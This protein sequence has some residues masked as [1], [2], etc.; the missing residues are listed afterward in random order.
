LPSFL[1]SRRAILIA[2]FAIVVVACLT[3]ADFW[4]AAPADVSIQFVG[5]Q[6]CIDCHQDQAASFL[7]SHHDLAMDV[8]TE[9]TVLG[10][11]SDVTFEHHGMVNRL[12][13]EG[14]KFMVHTEGETGKMEDFEVKYVFGVDPLQ[15]YMVEFDRDDFLKP[16]ELPR[17]QV[18]R[19]SWDVVKKQWFYLS[20]PDVQ[21]K[22]EPGDPL[23][24]TGI[25]QRWQTMCADCHSTNLKRNFDDKANRY[26]TTFSEIDVSCEACHGP[27]SLHVE[28]A[29]SKSLFWDRRHG[30]GLAELKGNDPQPQ[31]ESCAP[32]HSRRGL[33]DIDFKAGDLY[34]DHYE[35]E[36]LTQATY[37]ADGQIKDEVY[38]FG[39][40]TQSRMYHK[41]IRCTDCH[42]PH[43]AKLKHPGNETC[44]SCHQHAAGKYDVPSH[45]H[46][47]VG[48][49]GAKCVNCHMPHTTYMA[50]DQRHDHSLRMPRPD[51][52]VELGTPN[53]CSSCHVNDQRKN[54]D[55]KTNESLGEYATWLAAAEG[56]DQAVAGAIAKTD[57]WC[58]D[59]C[60]KWYGADRKKPPHFAESIVEFRRGV[61]GAAERL[62]KLALA[63]DS[64][65]P[66]IARASAWDEVTNSES[67][68]LAAKAARTGLK[69]TNQP[70]L[71]RAAAARAMAYADP[72][73]IRSD[74][75]PALDDSSRLV[76]QA[77]ANSIFNSGIYRELSG[78]EQMRLD[79]VAKDIHESL[80]T[81]ND[82]GTAHLIWAMICESRGDFKEASE[83]YQKSIHVEP[84]SA[85]PRS[86][87]ATL[88]EAMAGQ[89]IGQRQQELL[90]QAK[91]LRDEELPLLK[92]DAELAPKIAGVQYRY[93]L[94]LYLAGRSKEA[95]EYLQRAV[96][97]EPEVPVFQQARDA[98]R[99]QMNGQ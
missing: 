52:S 8:A 20:P 7:G 2:G 76:R 81:A 51:L 4:S 69:Q 41:G 74:L 39:S 82:R 73:M 62:L 18:L 93:G 22:L 94:S 1:Q 29:S 23:H 96:E 32:C 44:T 77:A 71:V 14:K 25:A 87:L 60:E 30:Y 48:S 11:F 95:L 40:F 89:E 90:E 91:R 43:S 83:S 72:A 5:R 58:D 70:P 45:H 26:H 15:Q 55:S 92:R 36:R 84:N 80:M 38:E 78:T 53:A 24:W 49:E 75:V 10:D 31:L 65:A 63:D 9:D 88:F 16:G 68:T 21:E 86:N 47:P 54:L 42:D 56:G 33:L 64:V 28:L 6:Q 34:H 85:G 37:H 27:G 61:P 46:H 19:I 67:V 99:D 50:I 57:A 98:L 79:H 66:A 17:L 59:A 12:F 13:R 35:L 3:A 97:L